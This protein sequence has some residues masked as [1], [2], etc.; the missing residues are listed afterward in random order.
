[1]SYFS[2]TAPSNKLTTSYEI[3]ILHTPQKLT[4]GN[5][6]I[7]KHRWS[8]LVVRDHTAKAFEILL[9]FLTAMMASNQDACYSSLLGIAEYFRTFSPPNIKG[10]IQC[11][12]AVFN[13][14]PPPRVEVRTH[15]QL[16][17]I[18]LIHTRNADLARDH[19][20]KGVRN[21]RL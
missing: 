11:L 17:N 10:C 4:V 8:A 1:M 21:L 14:N 9:E 7:D 12:Q 18:L 16:G 13:L 3:R 5:A 20:T 15:L 2:L 6:S 19:L